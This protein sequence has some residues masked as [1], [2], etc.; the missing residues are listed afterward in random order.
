[1]LRHSSPPRWERVRHF[2]ASKDRKR[3]AMNAERDDY[4]GEPPGMNKPSSSSPYQLWL[5]TMVEQSKNMLAVT[6]MD[7]RIIYVNSF[8][9][10][11]LGIMS[12]ENFGD[13]YI[14]RHFDS[15]G[16]TFFKQSIIPTLLQ[17]QS[18]DYEGLMRNQ[19][20]GSTMPV[21]A[22]ATLVQDGGGADSRAIIWDIRDR[23]R[24]FDL[25]R[26]ISQRVLEHRIVADLARE[27]IEVRWL[28]LIRRAVRAVAHTLDCELVVFAQPVED[29]DKLH[30]I[31][32]HDVVAMNLNVLDGGPRS[33]AGFVVSTGQ[34][35]ITPDIEFE[36]RVDTTVVR[37]FGM[38]SGLAVPIVLDT[39]II[40]ALSLHTTR[41]RFFTED[42][43]AFLEAVASVLSSAQKRILL[44]RDFRHQ[45]LHDGLTGLPNRALV[46]DRIEHALET[47]KSDDS[48]V[49]LF[50]L[51]IDDFKTINDSLGHDNGDRLLQEIVPR[52]EAILHEGDTLARF[53]GDEFLV[54]CEDTKTPLDAIE[55]AT[56]I[57]EAWQEP[58]L[59]G[60][61]S[62]FISASIGVTLGRHNSDALELIREADTAMYKA[63]QGG[64]GRF[65]LY[66]DVMGEASLDRFQLA[67]DLH[68]AIEDGQLWIAYQPI[69][70][71]SNGK[72]DAVEALCRWTHPNKGEISPELFVKL[73]EETGQILKLGL[74]VMEESLKEAA[75][76]RSRDINVRLRVNVSAT[77]LKDENFAHEVSGI[78][79]RHGIAPALIGLEVT[80]GLLLERDSVTLKV[81]NQLVEMG[82]EFLV[83]DYGSGYSSL[84]SLVRFSHMSALKID[85]EFVQ[86]TIDER[87]GGIVAS[88][89]SLGHSLGMKVIAEGVETQEQFDCV[90]DSGCDFAQGYLLGRPVP[91]AII[92][93]QLTADLQS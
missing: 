21:A 14:Q 86:L 71:L 15:D 42:D 79:R 64:V 72:I 61:R 27:A 54:L 40:G 87:H 69:I 80:E 74:W 31:A 90:R 18:W 4:F 30:V 5:E 85:K 32:K 35:I 66:S 12:Q 63:K 8:G 52:I 92:L 28:D 6:D 19:S 78:L 10:K 22:F 67:T 91:E 46:T 44:E 62:V 41:R 24:R 55:L 13:D 93:S 26:Q 45:S 68:S 36:T 89:V 60:E 49:A 83:D 70:D 3:S 75:N 16:E 82:I 34:A 25:N 9:R 73:A 39:Q 1:M 29:S 56:R 20:D 53:G 23:R 2:S 84:G 65:A 11:L 59:L 50:M 48:I 47:S 77:Q 7:G 17:N 76:W 57:S 81:L 33:Q 88:V 43:V 37:R 58:F 38:L 51:D